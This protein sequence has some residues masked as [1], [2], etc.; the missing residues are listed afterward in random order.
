MRNGKSR[1]RLQCKEED[2]YLLQ[3]AVIDIGHKPVG[4][5][6]LDFIVRLL[7]ESSRLGYDMDER[8][9]RLDEKTSIKEWQV[10]FFIL[11]ISKEVMW[12]AHNDDTHQADQAFSVFRCKIAPDTLRQRRHPAQKT[13]RINP[14]GTA[15]LRTDHDIEF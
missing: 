4:G 10:S 1:H 7:A 15:A 14:L 12:I 5:I 13:G 3:Q 11:E 6:S 8:I 9:I 2:S